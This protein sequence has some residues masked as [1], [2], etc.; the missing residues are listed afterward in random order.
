MQ[1]SRATRESSRDKLIQAAA[2][3]MLESG[4]ASVTSRRVAAAAGLKPQLVHYYFSSMD[5]L[6]LA[7]YAWYFSGL[8]ERQGEI[9]AS[10]T[11]LRD[12]WRMM[13]DSRG[14][15]LNEFLA[16]ANHKPKIKR[17]IAAFSSRFRAEQV[18]LLERVVDPQSLEQ[19]GIT[20]A[21]LS[22]ML[23]SLARSLATEREFGIEQG[24]AE[25]LARVERM[26]EEIDSRY[27]PPG[28]A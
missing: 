6:Y 28:A 10:A 23:N 25:A 17:E 2:E 1:G 27:T 20:A 19:H 16:L 14:V 15:M 5:D 26:I 22:L 21:M 18:A 8:S 4:Y 7:V 3:L 9:T 13:C 12:L 24:H 11:P